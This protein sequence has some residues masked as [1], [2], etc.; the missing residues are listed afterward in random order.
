MRFPMPPQG[1]GPAAAKAAHN[2]PR[3]ERT[4]HPFCLNLR[5]CGRLAERFIWEIRERGKPKRHSAHTYAT[6]D[7]AR[8]AG[9]AALAA[10]IVEWRRTDVPVRDPAGRA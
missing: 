9:K 8:V 4:A 2:L 7:E 10:L 1:D 5:T 6:F 3:P